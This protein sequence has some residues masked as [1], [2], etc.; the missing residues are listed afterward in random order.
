VFAQVSDVFQVLADRPPLVL[1]GAVVGDWLASDD[2]AWLAVVNR[3][4]SADSAPASFINSSRFSGSVGE[5]SN[6][7]WA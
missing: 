3:E 5:I 2:A 4:A 7:K 1:V 6:W